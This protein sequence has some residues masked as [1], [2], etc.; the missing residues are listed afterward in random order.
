MEKLK[1]LASAEQIEAWKKEH[2]KVYS[3]KIEDKIAY[4]RSVDRNTYALAA[5]KVTT[6]PAKY[7]ETIIEN[8]W[9]G[10]AEELRKEDSYYFGLLDFV[11]DFMNKKKGTLG[12][13]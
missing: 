1:G 11:E 13:C 12:E 8:I 10:G 5:S 6:S 2:G 9:L 3:Y 4:L 7:G